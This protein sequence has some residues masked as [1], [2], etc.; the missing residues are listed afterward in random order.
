MIPSIF[1]FVPPSLGV[2]QRLSHS[3]V[4]APIPAIAAL[5]RASL[6]NHLH[7]PETDRT[8]RRRIHQRTRDIEPSPFEGAGKPE[9]LRHALA[10]YWSHRINGEHRIVHEVTSE[11]P[12]IAQLR[13]HY[14]D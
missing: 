6:G 9:P 5:G 13:Y 2:V 4:R 1:T 3:R 12:L 10:R 7:R 11:G 8:L 14:E